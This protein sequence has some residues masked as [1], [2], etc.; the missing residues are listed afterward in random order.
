MS[1]SFLTASA[2]QED[3]MLLWEQ[4]LVTTFS[5]NY[6]KS[7]MHENIHHDFI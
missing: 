3:S 1:K 5:K 7:H 6:G 4:K 2:V